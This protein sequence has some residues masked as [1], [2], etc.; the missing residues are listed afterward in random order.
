MGWRG[1]SLKPETK[2]PSMNEKSDKAPGRR[3]THRL[4]IVEDRGGGAAHWRSLTGLW[5]TRKGALTGL[6]EAGLPAGS[7]LVILP[8][9]AGKESP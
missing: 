2:E 7:R 4:W 5:P 6:V 1:A 8:A 9:R 3:P